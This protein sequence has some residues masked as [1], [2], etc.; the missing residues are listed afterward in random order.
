MPPLAA[1]HS[2]GSSY[3]DPLHRGGPQNGGGGYTDQYSP[4]GLRHQHHA[5]TAA[6]QLDY[7]ATQHAQRRAG[8]GHRQKDQY[9]SRSSS[10]N[11][12]EPDPYD[13]YSPPMLKPMFKEDDS[14][15]AMGMGMRDVP[16]WDSGR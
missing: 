13:P 9:G 6:L 10:W 15:Y 11:R 3:R 16:L 1:D 8:G 4:N 2:S 7:A 12:L 14:G 5:P